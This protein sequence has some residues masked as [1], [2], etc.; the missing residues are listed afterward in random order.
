LDEQDCFG[1]I[2]SYEGG[3]SYP[4]WFEEILDEIDRMRRVGR[5]GI[6]VVVF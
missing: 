4:V 5:E 2:G 3:V 6:E 1:V